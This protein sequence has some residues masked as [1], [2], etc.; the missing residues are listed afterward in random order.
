MLAELARNAGRVLSHRYLL[1]AV[2]GPA[3]EE[4]VDYL[5][6]AISALRRKLDDGAGAGAANLIVN[7]PAVGYRLRMS[8]D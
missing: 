3:H 8:G 6:V 7:E 4:N 2:W 5:R 1:R